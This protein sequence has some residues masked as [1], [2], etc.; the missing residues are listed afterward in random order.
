MSAPA[1]DTLFLVRLSGEIATKGRGTRLHFT[2]QLVRNLADALA[3]AGLPH[4]IQRE[5]SRLFVE[6]PAA[7]AEVLPRVFGVHSVSPVERRSWR[8]LDD[9]V[10]AGEELFAAAVAGKRFAV[11]ARRGGDRRFVPFRSGDVDRALGARLLPV[12]AGV[13]L[14]DPEVTVRVEIREG[15]AYFF[16]ERL[17]GFAGLPAGTEGRALSL[18]SGG[19][20][21]AVASWLLLKRGVRL[22]YLFCNLGGEAHLE[23]TLKVMK[24]IAERW[25]HGY[26]PRLHAVDLQPVVAGLQQRTEPRYWQVVLK[27]LMLHAANQL[28]RELRCDALVTGEAVGQVSSQTLRNLRAISEVAELPILRPLVGANKEEI[29]EQARRIGTYEL[30]AAVAE[31]CALHPRRPATHA[32][33]GAVREEEGKLDLAAIAAAVAARQVYD[34]KE[35]D[36]AA[37]GDPEL[38]VAAI[39][40]DAVLIDLRS[41]AAFAAWHH[42]RARRMDYF[43]ALAEHRGFPRERHYVFYCEV[44]L[45]SAHLAEVLRRDGFTAHHLRGGVKEVLRQVQEE[46]PALTALLSPALLG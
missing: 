23:G 40:Q 20:D 22:D 24:L 27:R 43:G 21:S 26:R 39:P 1:A 41:P 16:T 10:A 25:S 37:L 6:A 29:V 44:G 45:K 36:L 30:S 9:V 34:L 11:R 2:R 4:R 31:Y 14:G 17:P 46:D 28:A 8:T 38:A 15:E 42:P 12:A 19:F 35:L 7:A 13:D 18:V 5:W 32:G 33:V 3:A